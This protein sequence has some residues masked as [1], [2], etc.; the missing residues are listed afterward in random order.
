M[1]IKGPRCISVFVKNVFRLIEKSNE[2]TPVLFQ[3]FIRK[4]NLLK[5]YKLKLPE[6]DAEYM[7]TD[8]NDLKLK[9][10]FLN[11]V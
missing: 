5:G 9:H 4:K 8:V 1:N 6:N 7:K 2:Y 11:N 3:A 10:F